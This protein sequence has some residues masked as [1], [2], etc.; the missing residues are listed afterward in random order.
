MFDIGAQWVMFLDPYGK[1]V[2]TAQPEGSREPESFTEG[3][4]RAPSMHQA[5]LS[6]LSGLR[7]STQAI[8]SPQASEH[9]GCRGPGWPLGAAGEKPAFDF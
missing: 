6:L 9:C 5:W 4:Q 2:L 7:P 8:W 3:H 1:T